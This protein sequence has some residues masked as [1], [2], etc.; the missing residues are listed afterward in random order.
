MFIMV[1]KDSTPCFNCHKLEWTVEILQY[2]KKK[3]N[4]IISYY[5]LYYSRYYIVKFFV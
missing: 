5:L 1:D 2:S 3:R 4:T